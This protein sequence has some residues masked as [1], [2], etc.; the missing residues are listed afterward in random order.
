MQSPSHNT[1]LQNNK[2]A[3]RCIGE[4]H[5]CHRECSAEGCWGPGNRLCLSCRHYQADQ[6]GDSECVASCDPAAGLYRPT[7]G[8]DSKRCMKCDDECELTCTGPGPGN[9]DRCAHAKVRNTHI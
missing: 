2:D 3:Q 8:E 4:G 1:L 9:C 7:D 5:V 6:A